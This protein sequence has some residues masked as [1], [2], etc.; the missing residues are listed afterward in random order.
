[1]EVLAFSIMQA[2]FMERTRKAVYCSMTTI[3]RKGRPRSRI[4]HPIWDGLV[5]WVIS[6]PA[7]H[8]AKHLEHNPYVSLAYIHD[9][10]KPVYVDATA[11]WVDDGEEKQRIWDLHKKTPPPMGF[12]PEPHFGTI[13]IDQRE[14]AVEKFF[15]E[16]S[17]K[18]NLREKTRKFYLSWF[19][20]MCTVLLIITHFG[21]I[22]HKC[23]G[24]LK[25]SPWRIELGDLNA[26]PIIWRHKIRN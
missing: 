19:P 22:N 5:G 16:T 18:E 2:E 17:L 1:M 8:K 15:P 10:N 24:L 23:F 21:T 26:E 14:V 12:D 6:W 25:F 13:C 4:M 9:V 3:D 7:S 20:A 11:E